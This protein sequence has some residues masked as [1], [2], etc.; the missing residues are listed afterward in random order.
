MNLNE[1]IALLDASP[2]VVMQVKN[3]LDR[4]TQEIKYKEA[5]IQRLSFELARLKRF[6]FGQ[7]SEELKASGQMDLFDET[8][9]ADIE[10]VEAELEQLGGQ[11]RSHLE[12]EPQ[13]T[14]PITPGTSSRRDSP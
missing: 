3:L 13:G 2:E 7:R 8:L 1:E 5:H 10:A 4:L 11:T 6:R 9:I 14:Q 12:E